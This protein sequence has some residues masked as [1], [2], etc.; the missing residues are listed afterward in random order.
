M[1][2]RFARSGGASGCEIVAEASPITITGGAANTKGSWID[3]FASATRDVMG[4]GLLVTTAQFVSNAN[5]GIR[6]DIGI[7]NTGDAID[8]I[9]VPDATVGYQQVFNTFYFPIHVRKGER[10]AARLQGTIASETL[11]VRPWI[12]YAP[13]PPAWGGFTKG[14]MLTA[15]T[16]T[17]PTMGNFTN[18][19]YEE[20]IASTVAPYRGFSYFPAIVNNSA[21]NISQTVEIGVGA[22]GAEQSLGIWEAETAATE[23][24]AN[25]PSTRYIAADV[26]AGSRLAVRKN[27]AQALTGSFIG[28]R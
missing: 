10:I 6:L 15:F 23:N 11:D 20:I 9:L 4:I 12:E 21:S 7:G 19:A 26:P 16:N 22:A 13:P 14:D 27:G 5:T 24:I 1:S 25:W 28:W 2:H 17:D 8:A 3:L 18:N